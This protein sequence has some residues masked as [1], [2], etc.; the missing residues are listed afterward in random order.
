MTRRV[1]Q[2]QEC[3]SYEGVFAHAEDWT[4]T[5]NATQDKGCDHVKGCFKSL[6]AVQECNPCRPCWEVYMTHVQGYNACIL[7]YGQTGS[8]KSYTMMG[9]PSQPGIIPRLCNSLFHRISLVSTP[10][11]QVGERGSLKILYKRKIQLWMVTKHMKEPW[12]TEDMRKS[13]T[14]VVNGINFEKEKKW[15]RAYVNG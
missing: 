9:T 14:I 6:T 2:V 8:G 11:N 13:P 10:D 12:S 3:D 1:L 7:A 5:R 4:H 15:L